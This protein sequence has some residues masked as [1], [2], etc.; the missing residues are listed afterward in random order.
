MISMQF[1][2][3]ICLK[4]YER[5]QIKV[6]KQGRKASQFQQSGNLSKL[7][8]V[9]EIHTVYF[10]NYVAFI[11]QSQRAVMSART[12]YER[13]H[14]RL[15]QEIPQLLDGRVDF[16]D[17]CLFAILRTQVHFNEPCD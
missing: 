11:V 16:F 2:V 10:Y 9:T 15:M 17:A 12:D 3:C 6:E 8:M 5:Q 7:D 4:E 14:D 1:L 13:V